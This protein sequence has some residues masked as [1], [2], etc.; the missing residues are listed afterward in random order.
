MKRRDYILPFFIALLTCGIL[1]AQESPA[2]EPVE[3]SP[4]DSIESIT[5]KIVSI[6]AQAIQNLEIGDLNQAKALGHQSLYW[7]NKLQDKFLVGNGAW[8][9]AKAYHQKKEFPTALQFYLQAL[10]DFAGNGFNGVRW[11][12]F[13]RFGSRAFLGS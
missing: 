1:T 2:S 7:A 4:S 12:C 11:T 6:Q 13:N 9:I 5:R 8:I 3:A 10:K